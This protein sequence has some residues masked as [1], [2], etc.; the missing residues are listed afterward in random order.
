MDTANNL[1][2]NVLPQPF[3]PSDLSVDGI[4]PEIAL[5]TILLREKVIVLGDAAAGKTSLIKAFTSQG[6][7]YDKNY[8]MTKGMELNVSEVKVPQ[9]NIVVDLFLYDM[10]GNHI[11][12]QKEMNTSFFKDASYIICVFDVSCRKSLQSVKS[13]IASVRS[14]CDGVDPVPAILVANKIDLREVSK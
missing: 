1:N 9:T 2:L 5:D 8:I 7:N 14:V 3:A 11:Y 13:W 6:K 4:D 10:G 12:N